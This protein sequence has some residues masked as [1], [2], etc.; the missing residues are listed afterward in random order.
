M[1]R[2]R[3]RGAFFLPALVRRT[4]RGIVTP[5]SSDTA[6]RREAARFAFDF[7]R[8]FAFT[9]RAVPQAA[10]PPYSM[11]ITTGAWSLVP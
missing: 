1:V 11:V 4:R 10:C 8:E 7:F 9:V 3:A 5:S 6:R 2:G